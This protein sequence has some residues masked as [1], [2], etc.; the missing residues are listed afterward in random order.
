M[1]R[2]NVRLVW[3]DVFGCT[4]ITTPYLEEKQNK[5]WLCEVLDFYTGRSIAT[6]GRIEEWIGGK[7]G[8]IV[9]RDEEE[10]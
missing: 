8:W 10:I 3:Y 4:N 1:P 7:I 2:S 9:E 5:K 6:G